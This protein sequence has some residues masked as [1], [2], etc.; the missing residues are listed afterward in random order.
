MAQGA[1]A[2]LLGLDPFGREVLERFQQGAARG[3]NELAVLSPRAFKTCPI[4]SSRRWRRSYA[5]AAPLKTA[6]S[7]G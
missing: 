1:A 3:V 5:R 7:R 2:V 4:S 6:A